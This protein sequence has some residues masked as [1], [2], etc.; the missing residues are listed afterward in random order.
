VI[1]CD[2]GRFWGGAVDGITTSSF[3]YPQL[4]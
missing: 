2:K 1:A 3:F 4:R